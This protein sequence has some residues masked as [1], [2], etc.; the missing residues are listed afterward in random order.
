MDARE[1]AHPRVWA[2]AAGL[3]IL[4]VAF[5]GRYGL[6][7]DEYYYLACAERLDWGY[8][9]H[10]PLSIAVLALVRA[11]LGDSLLAVRLLPAL[12]GG[13]LVLLTARLAREM[14]GGA[15][16]QSL[17]ALAVVIAPQYLV[18]AGYY[19]MNAF[20]LAFWAL[21]ALLVARLANGA[22]E[23][24]WLLLGLVLGLGLLNKISVMFFGAGLA[25]ALLLTPLRRHLARPSIWLGG[26]LAA[27]L[28]VPHVLWQVRHDWPT[29]EFIRNAQERKIVALGPLEFFLAQLPEIHPLNALVWLPGLIFLLVSR[30]G[31]PWRALGII[32]VAAL[33][34]FA[35]QHSKPYYLGPAY[36]MLLAAGGVA[37]E[38]WSQAGRRAWLRPALCA[39]LALG[40]AVVA[41]LVVPLLPVETLVAYQRA[42]GAAP[43]A[44]ENH[45]LGPLPQHF[46]DRFGWREMTDAVARA[47]AALPIDERGSALIVAS[48]Y[49]EAGALNYHGRAHGLPRAVSQHNNFYLWGPGRADARVVITVGLPAEDLAEAFESVVP[50][51][52]FESPWAMPYE[53]RHPVH[54]CRGLRLPLDEAWRR[55]K[56]FI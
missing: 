18:L 19:S 55:G 47:Y 37:W 50:A 45:S 11:L 43:S 25:A 34:I 24:L 22:D 13:A 2:L 38:A 33:V 30:A 9:D 48:N 8:V 17:A 46:A 40:G 14:R 21:G 36:P 6:F 5:G 44:A 10:P 15:F 26:L 49:G 4:Q 52:R 23:R 27:A 32:Y 53:T 28:F 29:L 16:A 54:V 7:R 42:L 1:Q 20:D 56:S 31:R 12:L 3:V 35:L 41:P 39:L 51:A